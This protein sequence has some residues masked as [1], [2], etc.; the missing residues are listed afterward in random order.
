MKN[1]VKITF[2]LEDSLTHKNKKQSKLNIYIYKIV[3]EKTK[4]IEISRGENSPNG[5]I[6]KDK[7]GVIDNSENNTNHIE[8][9]IWLTEEEFNNNEE[10]YIQMLKTKVNETLTKFEE[11]ILLLRKSLN[12][13]FE[14][15]KYDVEN[16]WR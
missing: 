4:Y 6:L 8:Y 2:I 11:E 9:S 16:L 15:K 10:Y 5:R 7:L 3:S 13:G 14:L 1:I 12:E